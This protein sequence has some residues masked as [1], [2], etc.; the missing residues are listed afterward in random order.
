L[1]LLEVQ[2]LSKDYGG[3]EALKDV[4]LPVD[5]GEVLG[6]VGPTGSGKTT[7]LRLINLL[8]RPTAGSITFGGLK[9]TEC[10]EKEN[11]A[12]RRRM[13]MVF[14]KPVMFSSS[15]YSNVSYGLKIRGIKDK[16]EV[17]AVLKEIGLGSYVHREAPTLSGGEAQRV[18]LARAIITKPELLLMDEPT[19]NLDPKM[20]EIIGDLILRQAEEGVAVILAT[21]D[22]GQCL[23]L[24]D[25]VVVLVNG[26][27]SASGR[28]EEVLGLWKRS[29]PDDFRAVAPW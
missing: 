25:R 8:E 6:L 14:Q 11:V 9:I 13:A 16:G 21:H 28:S 15:V 29:N 2:G 26:R 12:I 24:S 1:A 17:E 22:M 4:S 27:V 3:S 10:S 19:A 18:A 23:R 5:G 20:A 7:L